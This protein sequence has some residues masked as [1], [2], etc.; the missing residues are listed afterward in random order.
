M[1]A[2]AEKWCEQFGAVRAPLDQARR[3][4]EALARLSNAF[5]VPVPWPGDLPRRIG[6]CVMPD[7]LDVQSDDAIDGA[8][9]ASRPTIKRN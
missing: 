3:S 5:P 9:V 1:A 4:D 2:F 8:A 6:D 7:R